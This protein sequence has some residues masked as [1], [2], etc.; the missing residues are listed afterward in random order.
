M[1]HEDCDCAKR[2]CYDCRRQ[3]IDAKAL[4]IVE[5][6]IKYCSGMWS[7]FDVQAHAWRMAD[8]YRSKAINDLAFEL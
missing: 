8:Q 2:T 3:E 6:E 1:N 4:A 7:K 5:R